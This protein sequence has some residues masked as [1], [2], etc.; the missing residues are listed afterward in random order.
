M[1]TQSVEP[2]RSPSTRPQMIYGVATV[3]IVEES[4]VARHNAERGLCEVTEEQAHG[5]N[6]LVWARYSVFSFVPTPLGYCYEALG[7]GGTGWVHERNWRNFK[8]GDDARS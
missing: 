8:R 7:L 1:N 2:S 3:E 6:G 4:C 5:L